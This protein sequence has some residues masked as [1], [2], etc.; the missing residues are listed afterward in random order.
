M[1]LHKEVHILESYFLILQNSLLFSFQR[2]E[3]GKTIKFSHG[4]AV[5]AFIFLREH[6]LVVG[7]TFK[8]VL[9]WKV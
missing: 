8:I 1:L 9:S 3:T 7:K 6:F 5:F 2:E 4:W